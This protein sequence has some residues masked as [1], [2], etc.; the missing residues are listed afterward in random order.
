LSVKVQGLREEESE[1]GRRRRNECRAELQSGGVDVEG[2]EEKIN[3]KSLRKGGNRS[4][5]H[6]ARR[7]F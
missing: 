2:G 4:Q 7:E 1:E 3:L 6:G 5:G